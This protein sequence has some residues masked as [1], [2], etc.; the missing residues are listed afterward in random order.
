M[1]LVLVPG[2]GQKLC[3]PCGAVVGA[4]SL[5][6]KSCG[7]KLREPMTYAPRAAAGAPKPPARVFDAPRAG[8]KLHEPCGRYV[9]VRSPTCPVC[10]NE[11]YVLVNVASLPPRKSKFLNAVAKAAMPAPTA[12]P[13]DFDALFPIPVDADFVDG[14]GEEDD[15]PDSEDTLVE[16]NETDIP[17]GELS[18]D[19]VAWYA[20]GSFNN[21]RPEGAWKSKEEALEALDRFPMKDTAMVA[22]YG[23]RS[24]EVAR[25]L[26]PTTMVSDD[27]ILISVEF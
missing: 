6:C 17:S 19:N 15:E 12:L 8:T 20:W 27:A 9:G 2:R 22:L 18:I 26:D 4:R 11:D 7:T 24:R 14:F 3:P 21:Q 16:T 10:A 25:D 13:S 1:N 23:C 5:A